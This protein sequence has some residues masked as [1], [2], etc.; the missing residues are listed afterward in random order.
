MTEVERI[1]DQLRRAIEGDAWHGPSV[2]HLLA[3]VTVNQAIAK[4]VGG[5]HSIFELL[6]HMGAWEGVALKRLRGSADALPDDQNWPSENPSDEAAWND[7]KARFEHQNEQLRRAILELSDDQLASEAP[8]A[9][10][11]FYYLLHGVI[12]HDLYHGGQIALLKR[13]VRT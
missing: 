4:P 7:C 12:Q 2:Q 1:E 8:G 3:D 6:F 13:A 9:D 5:A 10:Y 11:S